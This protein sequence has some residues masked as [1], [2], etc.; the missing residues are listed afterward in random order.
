MLPGFDLLR[1]TT[2]P[3]ALRLLAEGGR[4]HAGGS[5]LLGCLR[6]RVFA[7]SRLVSLGGVP[8][9]AGITEGVTGAL[10]IGAM[11]RIAELARDAR[12][13]QRATA[14]AVAAG[15]VGSP[16]LRNQGTLGGNLCQKP[17]CWYYRGDFHCLR[18]GGEMCYAVEGEN[19]HHCIFGGERCF[20]VHPSD[21]APALVALGALLRTASA[22]GGRSLAVEELFVR[23]SDDPTRETALEEAEIITEIVIPPAGPGQRSGYT[24]LRARAVW[25]FA[26]AGAAVAAELEGGRI[27]DARVVLS[28]VAPAPWRARGAEDVLHGRRLDA[29]TIAAAAAAAVANAEPLSG[30]AA[31]IALARA[32]VTRQLEALATA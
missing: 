1:P 2:L 25:D 3:E 17:R 14:L 21:T 31:K 27:R 4:V 32:A 18:K 8:D 30:N 10:R 23:P 19:Q 9:L 7:A 6:D 26:L 16:Q 22:S 28:G 20:Y 12:V 5:D 24:K 29:P 15:E 13:R 11:T